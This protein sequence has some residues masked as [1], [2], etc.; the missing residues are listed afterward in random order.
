MRQPRVAI[1]GT[2]DELIAIGATPGPGQVVNSNGLMLACQARA[3]G[4]EVIDLGVARDDADG[5]RAA[6]QRGLDADVLI[7]C[8]GISVGDHDLVLPT[9]RGL[10]GEIVFGASACDPVAQPAS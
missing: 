9:L 10:G 7:T 5:L 8:G 3:A 1:L 2:G 4:A 6:L